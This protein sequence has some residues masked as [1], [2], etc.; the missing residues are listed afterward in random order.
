MPGKTA[1]PAG[2]D[3]AADAPDSDFGDRSGLADACRKSGGLIL[4]FRRRSCPLDGQ[5]DLSVRIH[6]K[7]HDLD[8]LTLGQVL[9]DI[10]DIG[11]GNFRDMYHTGLALGQRN[12]RAEAGD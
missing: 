5:V 1:A 4:A 11:V 7:D 2:D 8:G 10:R 9:A 12:E 3:P 6:S